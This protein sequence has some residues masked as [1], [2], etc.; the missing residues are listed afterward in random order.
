MF[1]GRR[2][3]GTFSEMGQLICYCIG[4]ITSIFGSPEQ[5]RLSTCKTPSSLKTL[6]LTCVA[7]DWAI[8]TL[9]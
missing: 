9:G 6:I 8:G 3:G 2:S 4:H 5:S 1:Q 7:F